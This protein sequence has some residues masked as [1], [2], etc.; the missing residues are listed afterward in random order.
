MGGFGIQGLGFR[1]TGSKPQH[2]GVCS[3]DPL[4]DF[5]P[6]PLTFLAKRRT[7]PFLGFLFLGL[8]NEVKLF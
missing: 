2:D 6:P 5:N 7:L 8:Y 4:T 3:R 1:G